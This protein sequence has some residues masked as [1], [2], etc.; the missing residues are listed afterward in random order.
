MTSPSLLRRRDFLAAAAAAGTSL[1][2]P[3][4]AGATQ[5]VSKNEI[6]IGSLLD[7]SGPVVS[8]GKGILNGMVFRAEQINARGG[9]HGRKLRIVAEDTG[10]DP[11]KGVLGAQKLLSQD[12]IFAMIG[13]IGT[14]VS[15]PTIPMCIERNVPH[16]FPITAHKGNYE[17]LHKLKFA[18]FM[19][20]QYSAELGLKAIVPKRGYKRVGI[21]YQDDEFGLEVLRGAEKGLADMNLK[22]VEVTSFKRGATEFSSQIQKLRA[23][24]VEL[25]LLAS[26][27]RETIGAMATARQIGLNAE[28]LTIALVP[29]V[30]KAGGK[31]VEGLI[32]TSEVSMIYRDAPGNSK[33]LNDWIDQFQ[34]RFKEEPDTWS[35]L[36]WMF[37]DIVDK[38]AEK[39][40]PNLT[41]EA[42]VDGLENLT[43]GRTFL[44]TPEYKWT[45]TNHQGNYLSRL[46]QIQNGR[47]T[48]ISD[49]MSL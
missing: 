3:G 19:P 41:T 26:V 34:A 29:A 23:A 46:H 44:G 20:Y 31:A 45:P 33:M 49:F 2:L 36:G 47:W 7:L 1:V 16:M 10:Y 32:A 18:S 40:G 8:L 22:L 48:P 35:V 42:F 37:I 39:V 24:N 14:G 27:V 38:V 21:L 5:G 12:K 4:T 28:F 11:K 30:A 6:L 43:Y 15:L 9:I 17:P 13:S 25:V